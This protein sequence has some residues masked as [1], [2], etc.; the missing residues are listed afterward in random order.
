MILYITRHNRARYKAL[1]EQMHTQRKIA[2]IDRMGW[3]LIPSGNAE[4]DSYD[5]KA[6]YLLVLDSD[7]RL[8]GSVRLLETTGSHLLVDHFQH[9][10]HG[11]PPTGPTVWEISR[12]CYDPENQSANSDMRI[13]QQLALAMMETALAHD[14]KILT[15]VTHI[16][17]MTRVMRY[18]WE[19][20][21]LGLATGIGAFDIGAFKMAVNDTSLRRMRANLGIYEPVI[22]LGI[23]A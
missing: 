22:Q 17:V 18:G 15:F 2:F 5:S 12:L 10:C 7:G 16:A 3:D 9:L 21:P 23:A 8:A 4:V 20:E 13:R 11:V 14:V 1:L 19:I 6:N